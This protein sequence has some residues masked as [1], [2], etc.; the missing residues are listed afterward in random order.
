MKLRSPLLALCLLSTL[1]TLSTLTTL[2][3]QK[4][5][6][7]DVRP[8]PP[9]LAS[10]QAADLKKWA[11]YLASDELGGRLTGST[12]QKLAAEYITEHFAKLGL[13]PLGDLAADG[14]RS[15]LQKYPVIRHYLARQACSLT[16]GEKEFTG[17]F[18]V[19]PGREEG[20]DDVE[21]EGEFVYAGLV[22]TRRFKRGAQLEDWTGKIP[23][24][25]ID[26]PKP[27]KRV[28][29]IERQFGS[30]FFLLSSF[31]RRVDRLT[32]KG[33][34][35][36]LFCILEDSAAVSN[37]LTYMS[38]APGQDL[39]EMKGK[40][41]MGAMMK[42][43]RPTRTEAFL[44]RKVALQILAAIGLS[45]AEARKAVDPDRVAELKT[46]A[47]KVRLKVSKDTKSFATNVVAVLRGS[48]PKLSHEAVLFSAHMDHVGKRLD[49]DSY[50]GAD[51]NASGTAGL[52]AI[53]KA[54]ASV[55]AKA[56]RAPRRSVIFLAVS[57][58]ELGLW[59]SAYYADHPTWPIENI[60]ADVNTD[61]IGRTGPES[62]KLDVMV[63]PSYRHS[64][65]SSIVHESAHIGRQLG[66]KFTS[67]DKYYARSDH[68]NFAKLGIPVVFFCNGVHDDYHQVSDHSDKLDGDRMETITRLA[69]WTGYNVAQ[70]DERPKTLGR[71]S[72]WF[73][74]TRR[75][76]RKNGKEDR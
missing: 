25:V 37:M 11:D 15:Y 47:G 29:P 27:S 28:V 39:L 33:A 46:P 8:E 66:L 30:G 20:A 75:G 50:N 14:K 55:F 10:V 59:G 48:D 49:G 45:E 2:T 60:V 36:A 17:G 41:G 18:A 64:K 43:M 6:E 65:F 38:I 58:E 54:F 73:D 53:A 42:G 70:A 21:V 40:V 1:S 26:L 57:G 5:A 9:G 68:F 52:M 16:L 44:S 61:M 74:T 4:P 63:T 67:G 23:V 56:Q 12:G 72:G 32:R 51:D 7:P 3:A 34:K 62:T 69:Y 22:N 13:E 35:V 19:I 76:A 31:K 24:F 71:T